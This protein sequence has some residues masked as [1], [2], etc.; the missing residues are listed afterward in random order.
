[1][2][3]SGKYAGFALKARQALGVAREVCRKNFQGDFATEARVLRTIHFAH[4]AGTQW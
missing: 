1:M 4:A 3:Q 2:A